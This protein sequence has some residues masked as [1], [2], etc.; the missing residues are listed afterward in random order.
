MRRNCLT[1]QKVKKK[2]RVDVLPDQNIVTGKRIRRAVQKQSWNDSGSDQE[3]DPYGTDESD[4]WEPDS[5][6]YSEDYV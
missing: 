2:K 3:T 6:D 5:Y 1:G 4:E